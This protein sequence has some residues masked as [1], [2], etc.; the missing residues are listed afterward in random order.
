MAI[1][2]INYTVVDKYIE[3]VVKYEPD[4]INVIPVMASG[5]ARET[6]TYVHVEHMRVSIEKL[7]QKTEELGVNVRVWCLPC[8]PAYTDSRRLIAY[9]C[10]NLRVVDIS[11]GGRL[12][13]CDVTNVEI[14]R[15]SPGKLRECIESYFSHDTVRLVLENV[16]DECKNCRFVNVCRGGCYARA[17][18]QFGDFRR[19]DPLCPLIH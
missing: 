6:L 10:R 8:L 9:A 18:L 7:V 2:N 15:W 19:K 11:P 5:R 1:S 16:P 17:F 13:L 14:C 3:N 4:S 12:L